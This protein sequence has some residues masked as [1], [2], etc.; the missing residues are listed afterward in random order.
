MPVKVESNFSLK[1][2]KKMKQ[3]KYR[4]LWTLFIGVLLSIGTTP[5][6]QG[7]SEFQL[8]PITTTTLCTAALN[9]CPAAGLP[10]V[11]GAKLYRPTTDVLGHANVAIEIT[12]DSASYINFMG[13]TY[14]AQ[15]G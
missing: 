2:E 3:K 1:E 7:A 13:C 4:F 9:N 8:Q 10:N 14:L 11:N 12:H 6:V 15:R 5:G